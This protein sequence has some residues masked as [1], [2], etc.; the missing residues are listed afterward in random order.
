MAAVG[1]ALLSLQ[2]L[3]VRRGDALVFACAVAFATHILLLGR[4]APAS[5]PTGWPWSSWPRPG[6][7][8]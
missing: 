2:R 7:S 6:C 5:P 4:Y 3:E 8:P 1:L